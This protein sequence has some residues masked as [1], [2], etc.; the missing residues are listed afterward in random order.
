MH[1]NCGKRYSYINQRPLITLTNSKRRHLQS[2]QFNVNKQV[3]PDSVDQYACLNLIKTIHDTEL[4]QMYN[5]PSEISQN[6]GEYALGWIKP[7]P[8]FEST[9]GCNENEI[10]SFDNRGDILILPSSFKDATKS[11]EHCPVCQ[12]LTYIHICDNCYPST[13]FPPSDVVQFMTSKK[14]FAY[15]NMNYWYDNPQPFLDSVSNVDCW[16]INSKAMYMTKGSS[17]PIYACIACQRF[18]WKNTLKSTELCDNCSF[19]CIG[20]SLRYCNKRHCA[21]SC[22]TCCKSYCK[23][24]RSWSIGAFKSLH[25]W[26]GIE[27][28]APCLNCFCALDEY[29]SIQQCV[30]FKDRFTFYH[31]MQIIK[32]SGIIQTIGLSE[33][34]NDNNN[35]K[36][37][38]KN[39]KNHNIIELIAEYGNGSITRCRHDGCDGEI[40]ILFE[41]INGHFVTHS[42]KCNSV[43]CGKRCFI[44]H[45]DICENNYWINK[46]EWYDDYADADEDL[47]YD[48]IDPVVK[49]NICGHCWYHKSEI[50]K[51]CEECSFFCEE[52]ENTLCITHL[53]EECIRCGGQYCE[54]VPEIPYCKQC[55]CCK[56]KVCPDCQIY[57]FGYGMIQCYWLYG[58]CNSCYSLNIAEKYPSSRDYSLCLDI[59]DILDTT[60]NPF[61]LSGEHQI[62]NIIALY[63]GINNIPNALIVNFFFNK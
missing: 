41:Q 55:R 9:Y 19:I 12:T 31:L 18:E 20:C 45:C 14:R 13:T 33:F 60:Y 46:I 51:V 16:W 37:K 24:C 30:H 63:I 8:G 62:N 48:E 61:S 3:I 43:V 50:V 49:Q 27:S 54:C 39:K 22:D 59:V 44:H 40:S 17:E 53:S 4:I 58:V 25:W 42:V 7:C 28:I 29:F 36:N 1:S 23:S 38:N 26:L 6:I 47:E 10:F 2:I 21:Y 56:W 57:Y 52:C 5:I 11:L 32:K 15:S 35:N 34:N